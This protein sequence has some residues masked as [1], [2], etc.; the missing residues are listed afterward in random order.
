L[1]GN[2][3]CKMRIQMECKMRIQL[4]LRMLAAASL[5]AL[6]VQSACQSAPMKLAENVRATCAIVTSSQ[7]SEAEQFA[8]QELSTFL[9]Q[10]TGA[11][12]AVTTDSRPAS[13]AEIVLGDTSRLS[14]NDI[15]AKLRPDK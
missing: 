1:R 2:V 6:G 15:P 4:V 9:G 12:F 5:A 10:M 13:G 3:E 14:M 8:A 11:K 7:V